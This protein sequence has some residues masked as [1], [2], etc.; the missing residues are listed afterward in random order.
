M[1]EHQNDDFGD[2][3]GQAKSDGFAWKNHNIT[4]EGPNLFRFAPPCKSLKSVGKWMVYDALHYGYGIPNLEAPDK[5]KSK[6]FR[7]ILVQ[8][9]QS[10]MITQDCPE[11]TLLEQRKNAVDLEK[12]KFV[13]A[14][15]T[16]EDAEE[17]VKGARKALRDHN[18]EKKY[19]TLAKNAAG[20]WGVLK[21][22]YKLKQALEKLMAEYA[23]ENAGTTALDPRGG[24]WFSFTRKGKGLN[25]EYYVEVAKES[26]GGGKFQYKNGALTAQDVEGITKCPDLAKVNDSRVL[27]YDQILA[28][29][30][31]GGDPTIAQQV[32][33]QGT[34]TAPAAAALPVVPALPVTVPAPVQA[35]A[36]VQVVGTATPTPG[37]ITAQEFAALQAQM[38]A[39]QAQQLAAAAAPAPQP[40]AMAPAVPAPAQAA[41]FTDLM[42]LDPKEFLAKFPDPNKK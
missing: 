21:L 41:G 32:F 16:P 28:L 40:V 20:E 12:G 3:F 13:A 26:L 24:L 39:Y 17:R 4:E 36:P 35:T 8:D 2:F 6:P 29:V 25:T 7:C 1:D 19:Y 5:P 15:M 30:R 9:R 14:G 22:G 38:A 18:L 34:R 11:C 23:K 27:T 31:S 33:G 42:K 10:K 37:T